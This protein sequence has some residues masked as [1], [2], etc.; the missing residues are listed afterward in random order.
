MLNKLHSTLLILVIA[1]LPNI[2][3]ATI[4][5]GTPGPADRPF[6]VSCPG[7]ATPGGSDFL[8]QKTAFGFIL[9]HLTIPAQACN[10]PSLTE[11]S[12]CIR[13]SEPSQGSLSNTCKP[14]TIPIGTR[15]L[16]LST[17]AAST[18]L[19]SP[20]YST[21]LGNIPLSLLFYPSQNSDWQT[22]D[23]LL[24]IAMPTPNGITPLI[25][26]P[27]SQPPGWTPPSNSPPDCSNISTACYGQSTNSQSPF[28]FSGQAYQCLIETMNNVFFQVNS[29]G[30]LSTSSSTNL[31]NSFV[32]FQNSLKTAI[33]AA[34]MMY[35]IFYGI[36][37]VLGEEKASL[38]SMAMFAIKL[39]LVLY[40]AVGLGP[41]SFVNNQQTQENGTTK[42]LLPFLK[43]AM[44]D[45]AQMVFAAGGSP[46]LCFFDPSTYPDGY[47]Y[48]AL[49]DSI[50]CRIG[51]YFGMGLMSSTL[52]GR[53]GVTLQNAT[54]PQG[55]QVVDFASTSTSSPIENATFFSYF[56]VIF[57]YLVGL[58][59]VIVICG[60]TFLIIFLGIALHFISSFLVCIV[61]L[62][63]MI[64]ISPIFVTFALFKRTKG[65]FD[66]WL[67]ILTSCALQPAIL[68]GF[69]A[70]VVTMFD[71]GM[72][73]GCS[74]STNT[75]RVSPSD[76]STPY[77]LNTYSLI[78]PGTSASP[79][80]NTSDCSSS[81]GYKMKYYASGRGWQTLSL[82]IFSIHYL[83]PDA[84]AAQYTDIETSVY[85][86]MLCL[87]FYFF[88]D[89][90]SNFASDLTGG[91]SMKAVT[92]SAGGVM[93]QIV[94]AAKKAGSAA[95]SAAKKAS[96]SSKKS[97][98]DDNKK[99][100]ADGSN[101]SADKD[102]KKT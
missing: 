35:V 27:R 32:A 16:S 38:N 45:F 9:N 46:G 40:F 78:D 95:A 58:N 39:I 41:V 52:Q 87:L 17:L 47:G 94:S 12:L 82:I 79:D 55:V 10:Q 62:Y 57:G 90:M 26:Q 68:A 67:K 31:L 76:G 85:L 29:C 100:R 64:Y 36:R 25:C 91:P 96:E 97:E 14:V 66:S 74:F 11:M 60:L 34:M 42:I 13:S 18:E 2:A 28:N 86:L 7:V 102:A 89:S 51:Y 65:Y 43:G 71:K 80:S 83:A 73:D 84:F 72:Y 53:P 8:K 88:S 98:A 21:K 56:Y 24:C 4:V 19:G 63:V 69:L 77:F 30:E 5:S 33:F 22:G 1:M 61:T 59:L 92:V 50:D 70:L 93:D 44:S 37:V 75:F 54:T 15:G 81:M 23:N 48:Y 20:P 3:A 99:T 101:N 49:F 6:G